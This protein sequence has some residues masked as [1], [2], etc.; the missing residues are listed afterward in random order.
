[1]YEIIGKWVHYRPFFG[2][3]VDGKANLLSIFK[4]IQKVVIL[5]RRDGP[6]AAFRRSRFRD[7][8]S[9]P[10]HLFHI[11]NFQIWD[12]GNFEKSP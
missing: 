5:S 10:N 8:V 3:F 6:N 9:E 11:F 12:F 7:R 4:K 1:M 2:G